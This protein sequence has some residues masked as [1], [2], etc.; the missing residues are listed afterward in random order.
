[1]AYSLRRT[2]PENPGR[3]DYIIRCEG[4]DVGRV[5]LSKLPEGERYVWTIY[6]NGHVPLVRDVP[7]SGAAMTLSL[8][9][10]DFKKSYERGS[11]VRPHIGT[12]QAAVRTDHARL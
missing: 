5:Y 4:L 9:A 1:M 11:S 10:A 6:I 8:A 12:D 7:I 2:W 3:E